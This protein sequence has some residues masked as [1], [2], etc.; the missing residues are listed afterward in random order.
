[1]FLRTEGQ[2]E[3]V[4]VDDGIMVDH[5]GVDNGAFGDESYEVPEVGIGDVNHG[6]D[7]EVRTALVHGLLLH[8]YFF[9]KV[10]NRY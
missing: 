10:N 1:M 2:E 5:F 4:V 6:G 7:G 9:Y 3:G 8:L